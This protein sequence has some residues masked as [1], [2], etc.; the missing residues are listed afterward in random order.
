MSRAELAL[1]KL[2]GLVDP[3]D[4][5]LISRWILQSIE[6]KAGKK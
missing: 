1:E 6:Q 3:D 5:R 2:T 4:D